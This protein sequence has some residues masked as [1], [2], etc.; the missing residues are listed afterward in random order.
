LERRPFLGIAF[1][2]D[3]V[4]PIGLAACCKLLSGRQ[5]KPFSAAWHIANDAAPFNNY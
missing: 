5:T 1:A 3:P 2:I 4:H